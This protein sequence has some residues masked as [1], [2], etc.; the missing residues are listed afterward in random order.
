MT[1]KP[2]GRPR[3]RPRKP[4]P[5][6]KERTPRQQAADRRKQITMRGTQ[7]VKARLAREERRVIV[8]ESLL[9]GMSITDIASENNVSKATVLRDKNHTMM[10]WRDERLTNV[11]HVLLAS[12]ALLDKIQIKLLTQ[13]EGGSHN[14]ME[15]LLKVID[16]RMKLYGLNEKATAEHWQKVLLDG[17][18]KG[19]GTVAGSVFEAIREVEAIIKQRGG[20]EI[21]L[22]SDSDGG[23]PETI[24]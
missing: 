12:S 17:S 10:E 3:G 23:S 11:D 6:K 5:P 20:E 13:V 16:R 22:E 9:K 7:T 24:N 19:N 1:K 21:P 14:A 8:S 2:T 4:K 15:L 18:R